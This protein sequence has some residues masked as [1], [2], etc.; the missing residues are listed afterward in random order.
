[1]NMPTNLWD[2]LEH[3][4][5][6]E[7]NVIPVRDWCKWTIMQI[8]V[9]VWCEAVRSCIDC[10]YIASFFDLTHPSIVWDPNT[11][12][13]SVNHTRVNESI[14]SEILCWESWPL[15][16]IWT[17]IINLSCILWLRD[18]NFT[19][20]STT[21]VITNHWTVTIN[22]W[23]WLWFRLG[24]WWLNISLPNPRQ[25][26]Q[27]LTW[28]D[29]LNQA[30]W[31]NWA[32]VCCDWVYDCMEPIIQWLQNQINILA[33]QLCPCGG[34]GTP[35]SVYEEG[36]LVQWSVSMLNFIGDCITATANPIT[37]HMVD[38]T[39]TP[40]LEWSWCESQTPYILSLCGSSVDLSCLATQT[41]LNIPVNNVAFV[42]KNGNDTTG[43]VQRLDK[44]FLTIQRAILALA[45]AGLTSNSLVIVYP[46]T[47]VEDQLILASGINIY[48]HQ[49][50]VMYWTF[51]ADVDNISCRVYGK[52]EQVVNNACTY[53]MAFISNGDNCNVSIELDKI[54]SATY[55]EN[56]TTILVNIVSW[57]TNNKISYKTNRWY[58]WWNWDSASQMM[59]MINSQGWNNIDMSLWA[60]EIDTQ[61][62]SL[63]EI[64]EIMSGDNVY[65]HHTHIQPSL[66]VRS[67]GMSWIW[68]FTNSIGEDQT[69]ALSQV[70]FDNVYIEWPINSDSSSY[71]DSFIYAPVDNTKIICNDILRKF[72]ANDDEPGTHKVF[73]VWSIKANTAVHFYGFNHIY[74]GN[75]YEYTL[76]NL[77]VIGIYNVLW[78]T[79]SNKPFNNAWVMW[80]YNPDAIPHYVYDVTTDTELFNPKAAFN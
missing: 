55:W 60:F 63:L 65:F 31:A 21:Q 61:N 4:C 29:N 74:T 32:D 59:L 53:R 68:N 26:W 45:T 62:S 64:F 11:C 28:S 19:D 6:T 13:L 24:N 41:E 8:P 51:I 47:Y 33:G 22:W 42:M 5:P 44:P 58:L 2:L 69:D 76:Y 38:I 54:T 52:W 79:Y 20:W 9:W 39:F 36:L 78:W 25:D 56:S 73:N 66:R 50:V 72:T 80:H 75:Y 16:T 43:E 17:N 71:D 57:Q 30:Y 3:P 34:D 46:W 37:N 7:S 10:E 14:F 67:L 1:M 12:S 40:T 23:D 18:F 35:L 70:Y 48:M 49:W 15:L 27:V 77:A